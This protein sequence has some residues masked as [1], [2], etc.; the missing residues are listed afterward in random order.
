MASTNYFPRLEPALGEGLLSRKRFRNLQM[1]ANVFQEAS[2]LLPPLDP[3]QPMV[4]VLQ[5]VEII[6]LWLRIRF[7]CGFAHGP[8]CCAMQHQTPAFTIYTK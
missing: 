8:A 7:A 3:P 6:G 2:N 1:E 4:P 5:P